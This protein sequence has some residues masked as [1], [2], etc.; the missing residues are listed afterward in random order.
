M[1]ERAARDFKELLRAGLWFR[2]LADD[3]QDA[4]LAAA[5][6]RRYT[7]GETVFTR[8]GPCLG[9]VGVL[10]GSIKVGG[11]NAQGDEAIL[12]FAEPPTWFGEVSILDDGPMTHDAVAERESLCIHIAPDALTRVLEKKPERWRDIG[13]L[14]AIKV[15]LLFTTMEEMA[16][17]PVSALVAR[18]LVHMTLGYGGWDDRSA[19]V[20]E[21]SQEQLATML[22][23]SRQTV[24][25]VLKDLEM[26][27]IVRKVYAG[28]EILD[29][30]GLRAV[31]GKMLMP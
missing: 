5:T 18:R 26:Q 23:I 22:A 10:E 30:P 29:L 8:G 15:R 20:L 3:F 27:N 7:P 12:V 31:A 13:R 28:I 1:K 9:L 4:L 24:N 14:M 2:G 6:L 11:V 16:L 25:T 21:V 17:L 19:R